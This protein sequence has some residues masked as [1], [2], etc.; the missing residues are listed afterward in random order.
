MLPDC[1]GDGVAPAWF[2]T[3]KEAG[4]QVTYNA[5]CGANYSDFDVP[6]Q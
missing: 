3:A 5:R 6:V 1:G 2:N 4:R